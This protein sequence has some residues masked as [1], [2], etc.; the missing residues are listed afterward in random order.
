MFQQEKTSMLE[1]SL[2]MIDLGLGE[3]HVMAA[4]AGHLQ[5]IFH[6]LKCHLFI[7]YKITQ[8]RTYF[9]SGR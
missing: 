6:H 3:A 9:L 4:L 1:R 8:Y 5:V 7:Y 2:D